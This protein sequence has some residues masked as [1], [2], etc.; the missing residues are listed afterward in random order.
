MILLSRY[1]SLI[2]C[3][4]LSVT[5]TLICEGVLESGNHRKWCKYCKVTYGLYVV[6]FAGHPIALMW[7]RQPQGLQPALLKPSTLQCR[8]LYMIDVTELRVQH[9]P[10]NR[11][12][13]TNT[14]CRSIG[15]SKN[16][17]DKTKDQGHQTD[18]PSLKQR[19]TP[20]KCWDTS[21][22]RQRT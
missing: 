2:Q 15:T 9:T 21:F 16:T 20:W 3:N 13:I 8:S 19:S 5:S 1:S 14:S 6:A 12:F 18:L 10:Q 17:K 4:C 7:K 22:C 11:A